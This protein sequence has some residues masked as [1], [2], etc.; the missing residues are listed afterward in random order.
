MYFE[1]SII[2]GTTGEIIKNESQVVNHK[3]LDQLIGS[4]K[5][6]RYEELRYWWSS[7]RGTSVIGEL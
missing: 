3:N 6:M 7:E 4:S 2:F 1:P 5:I